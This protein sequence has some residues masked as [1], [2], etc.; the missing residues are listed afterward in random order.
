MYDFTRGLSDQ[1][2]AARTI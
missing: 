1:I 2:E